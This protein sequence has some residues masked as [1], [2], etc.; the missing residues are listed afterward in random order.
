MSSSS[1]YNGQ[2]SKGFEFLQALAFKDIYING[3]GLRV[4]GIHYM[5]FVADWTV[6]KH[7]HSFFEFHYILKDNVYTTINGIEYKIKEGQCYL[8]SPGTYHSHRQDPGTGHLG[9]ALRWEFIG[10]T[11]AVPESVNASDEFRKLEQALLNITHQPYS[12]KEFRVLN[13]FM[14]ILKLSETGSS[15]LRLQMKFADFVLGL[16]VV[17]SRNEF[18]KPAEI[19]RTFHDN[20]IIDLVIAFLEENYSEDIDV[21]DVSNSVHMSYSYLSRLFKKRTGET[22]SEYLNKI[23]LK[24]AQ[25]LLLCTSESMGRIAAATGFNSEQY[26]CNNFKKYCGITPREYRHQNRSLDE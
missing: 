26:F 17:L 19:D 11:K 23:R 12:D 10:N 6:K 25:K 22:I 16:S 21:M 13:S 15:L 5:D 18:K 14:E 20:G 7:R 9:F 1:I 8:M 3:E 24:K 2:Y 4:M